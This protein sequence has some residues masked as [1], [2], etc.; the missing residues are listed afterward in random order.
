MNDGDV[1][2]MRDYVDLRFSDLKEAIA[3]RDV[4]NEERIKLAADEIARRLDVLNH[5]H[6][7]AVEAQAA[8][9]PREIFERAMAEF[10]KRI[11]NLERLAWGLTALGAVFVIA[12]QFAVRLVNTHR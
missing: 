3:R 10:N 9:V 4:M 11:V 2:R 8:T 1:I 12:I 5:A 6:E 7:D